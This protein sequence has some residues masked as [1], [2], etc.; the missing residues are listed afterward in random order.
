[1][2]ACGLATIAPRETHNWS[3]PPPGSETGTGLPRP[4]PTVLAEPQGAGSMPC[5]V[6]M[7]RAGMPVFLLLGRHREAAHSAW[8]GPLPSTLAGMNA[9]SLC[10]TPEPS[11]DL[12]EHAGWA[13]LKPGLMPFT[14]PLHPALC[15]GRD[16]L[17]WWTC[18][19]SAVLPAGFELVPSGVC[20]GDSYVSRSMSATSSA[21]GEGGGLVVS[22]SEKRLPTVSPV[23]RGGLLPVEQPMWAAVTTS[24]CPYHKQTSSSSQ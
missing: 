9:H 5:S 17:R 21:Q 7:G 8:P 12:V 10:I 22:C 13:R 6:V 2:Q 11:W 4:K 14:R 20:C 23:P 18:A 1:M 16:T 15:H 3:P 24:S 19:R